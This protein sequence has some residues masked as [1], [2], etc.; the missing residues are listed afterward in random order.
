MNIHGMNTLHQ[1]YKLKNNKK[2]IP[3]GTPKAK[4]IIPLDM[5]QT[6]EDQKMKV[7]T[8]QQFYVLKYLEQQFYIE[9]L[10]LTL[11]DRYTIRVQDVN[12]DIMELY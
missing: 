8:V 12:S 11:M 4:L 9:E 3:N 2:G 1:V 6:K 7:D 10:K 5:F